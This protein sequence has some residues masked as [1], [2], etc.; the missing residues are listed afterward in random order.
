VGG[1]NSAHKLSTAFHPETDGQTE[2]AN[3]SIGQTLR[4]FAN[5][6]QD[7]WSDL[8]PFV[9][10]SINNSPSAT[11]KHTPFFLNYG[12]HPNMP[13]SF[14]VDKGKRINTNAL[15]DWV[16]QLIREAQDR[17]ARYANT[18]R[19]EKDFEVGAKVMLK[20]DH[21]KDE[22]LRGQRS[23]KM[24]SRFMGP[25]RIIEKIGK[26]AYQL[27]L[28]KRL[29]IHDVINVSKLED[30]HDA[31]DSPIEHPVYL[32]QPPVFEEEYEV[33]EI[34]GKRVKSGKVQY[35]VKW[36]G[37]PRN[38]STWEFTEDLDHAAEAIQDYEQNIADN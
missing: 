37:Y 26:N 34:I 4:I 12:R 23:K 25:F 2:R 38:E 8:L 17:Q 27:E 5:Y 28:P 22:L 30:Y 13:S 3:R 29:K 31:K 32:K 36:L 15:K 14:K 21:Y 19:M 33:E 18:R 11:T 9:E 16:K 6:N 20:T 7:N 1:M 10:F 24:T 35:L